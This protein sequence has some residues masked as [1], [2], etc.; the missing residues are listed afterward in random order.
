MERGGVE[1]IGECN[2]GRRVARN[3]GVSHGEVHG[4]RR[5]RILYKDRRGIPLSVLTKS[6]IV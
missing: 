2:R 5:R 1:L 4:Q 6:A 3:D